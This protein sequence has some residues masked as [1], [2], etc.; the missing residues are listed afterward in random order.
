M[1]EI[2]R[3][4]IGEMCRQKITD[5]PDTETYL[6]PHGLSVHQHITRDAL[7]NTDPW[8]PVV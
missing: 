8:M 1:E 7:K 6:L 3:L 4:L 2:C 5:V